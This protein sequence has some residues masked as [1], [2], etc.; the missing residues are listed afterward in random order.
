MNVGNDLCIEDLLNGYIR[1]MDV[2]DDLM[3]REIK[4]LIYGYLG[5]MY[6]ILEDKIKELMDIPWNEF[7]W[8]QY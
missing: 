7:D 2:N 3:K 6:Y 4:M 8:C 1:S 5:S